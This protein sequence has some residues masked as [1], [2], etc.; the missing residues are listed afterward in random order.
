[1]FARIALLLMVALPAQAAPL[2]AFPGAEGFGAA[3]TG[4][5]GGAVVHVTTLNDSGPGSLRDAVAKGHRIVL[6]DVGGTIKLKEILHVS[7]DITLAGQ[8]APGEGICTLGEEVSFSKSHNVIVRYLRFRQGTANGNPKKSAV[9]MNAASD[10]ILDHVS[11]QWGRWDTVD[12]TESKNV[13]IQYSIIGPGAPPQR[14]GCLCESDGVTFSHNLWISNQSRNPKAKGKIQFVNNVVYNWGKVGFVGGHSAAAHE[15]DLIGNYFIKGPS[16][17]SSFTGEFAETDHIYQSGNVVDLEPDGQLNGRP[18]I[19]ADFHGVTMT[20]KP[21]AA[22][23]LPVLLDTA[24]AAYQKIAAGAG[25]SLHRDAIDRQLIDDLKSLGKSGKTI[26]TLEDM[27]APGE[28]PHA[29]APAPPPDGIPDAWKKAHAIDLKDP[30]ARNGDH[31]HDG[32]TNLEKY[33]NEMAA[34]P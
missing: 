6:F 26:A 3:A 29:S 31:N 4:G 25:C 34:S 8:T 14:F 20:D 15:A 17:G 18:V 19:A 11:I 16:S 7:S 23:P 9:G 24:D 33:L 28:L 12:M 32:Y 13:T 5:R 1:M 2:P 22:P 27:P 10:I 30:N 21:Q